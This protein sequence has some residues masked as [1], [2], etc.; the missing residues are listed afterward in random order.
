[1][2]NTGNPPGWARVVEWLDTAGLDPVAEGFDQEDGWGTGT[3]S[4][5]RCGVPALYP[6][7]AMNDPLGRRPTDDW[8]AIISNRNG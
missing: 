6:V 5:G 2:A 3:S 4:C 1:M 8:L 7:G